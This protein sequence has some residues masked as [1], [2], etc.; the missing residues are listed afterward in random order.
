M[1]LKQQW[2]ARNSPPHL[3][4]STGMGDKSLLAENALRKLSQVS[5]S[6]RRWGDLSYCYGTEH[7]RIKWKYLK[8]CWEGVGDGHKSLLFPWNWR[9]RLWGLRDNLGNLGLLEI[10]D[11]NRIKEHSEWVM[12]DPVVRDNRRKSYVCRIQTW[13]H[14]AK[15]ENSGLPLDSCSEKNS[16]VKPLIPNTQNNYSDLQ[17]ATCWKMI[18]LS[19]TSTWY[20]VVQKCLQNPSMSVW[21]NIPLCKFPSFRASILLQSVISLD[22]YCSVYQLCNLFL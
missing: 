11:M 21:W 16:E 22:D 6:R 7:K 19:L 2:G 5:V 4:L 10:T 12:M 8:K 17:V 20:S 14:L 3:S 15:M 13:R 1:A 9:I 18:L